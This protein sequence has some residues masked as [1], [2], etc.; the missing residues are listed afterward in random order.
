MSATYDPV[1]LASGG[2]DAVRF[3]LGDT[4]MSSPLVQDEEITFALSMRGNQ[5]GAVAMCARALSA[6]YAR[7]VTNSVDGIS[8]QMSAKTTQ[9]LKVAQEYE[10][11]AA[12]NYAMPYAGGLSIADMQ[13]NLDNTD[14]VPPLF[15]IGWTDNPGAGVP[16]Y[17]PVPTLDPSESGVY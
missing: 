6:K 14:A 11:K 15:N 8:A 4:D 9:F 2:K 7:L 12:V 5:Y 10:A 17:P 1:A 13:A 3:F 16:A